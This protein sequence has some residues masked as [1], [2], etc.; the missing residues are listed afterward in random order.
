MGVW[1]WGEC[2]WRGWGGGCRFLGPNNG[3]C[4][5]RF[6]LL[7]FPPFL[8]SLLF[9]CASNLPNDFRTTSVFSN[10]YFHPR[11]PRPFCFAHLRPPHD[12]PFRV[13]RDG[14]LGGPGN[15]NRCRKKPK[16]ILP[17]SWGQGS[18]F[19]HGFLNAPTRRMDSHRPDRQISSPPPQRPSRPM[20]ARVVTP[21]V[22]VPAPVSPAQ[23][24][25]AA[26]YAFAGPRPR[27]RET[28]GPGGG[29]GGAITRDPRPGYPRFIR[30]ITGAKSLH[31]VFHTNSK[32]VESFIFLF[33]FYFSRL[34]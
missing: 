22:P 19:S 6:L 4:L 21:S 10:I 26:P 3:E 24:S 33:Y 13:R 18:P 25:F 29:G 11:F 15:Q 1:Y 32:Q 12:S 30:S 14:C 34:M 28:E 16:P 20:A 5:C 27:P 31:D 2:V 8:H 9:I 23:W 17:Q 7:S